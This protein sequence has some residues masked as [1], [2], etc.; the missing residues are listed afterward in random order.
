MLNPI[1]T[2]IHIDDEQES[3]DAFKLIADNEPSLIYKG[4]F[5]D[6]RSAALF[7]KD[8]T[9][10]IAILDIMMEKED[11]FWL[12]QQIAHLP[13]DIV[14]LTSNAEY[15]LRAFDACALDYILKP[16]TQIKLNN[17]MSKRQIKKGKEHHSIISQLTELNRNFLNTTKRPERIFISSVGEIKV[18]N[19]AELLWLEADESYTHFILNNGM[20]MTASKRMKIYEEALNNHSDFV[21][22]H[23]KYIINKSYM[24]R[25]VKGGDSQK[26]SVEMK[27]K[28]ILEI[29]YQR[30]E[31]IMKMLTS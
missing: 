11:G 13:I 28:V 18:I 22:V 20:R 6:A 29:S 26:I 10:D 17:F 15:A 12:A 24:T 25:I 30:K 9:V 31:E 5:T 8:N 14:F 1:L 2:V 23:R 16:I 7:L 21:R 19:L 27:N 3:L 4:G